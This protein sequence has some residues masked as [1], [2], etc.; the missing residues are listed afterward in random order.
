MSY[1]PPDYWTKRGKGYE[2]EAID[3][4]WHDTENAPILDLLDTLDF[5]TVLEV[6]CGFGRVGKA[7]LDRRDIAYT[8]L[9]VSPDLIE[10][11]KR[12]LPDHELI[13]ADLATWDSD[14]Q[15]DLVLAVSVLGHLLPTDV[16]NVIAKLRRMAASHLV[17]VDWNEVGGQTS[18]QFGHDYRTLYGGEAIETL[19]GQQTIYH[20][21]SP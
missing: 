13:C 9:D 4:G 12:L 10:G 11:A 7:I 20:V 17:T 14:R 15:W 1:S 5:R 3:R 16:P 8:G 21:L 18:F 6:G 2:Q 19:Y